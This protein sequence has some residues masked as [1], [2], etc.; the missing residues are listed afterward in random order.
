MISD[1]ETCFNHNL[2]CALDDPLSSCDSVLCTIVTSTTAV[3]PPKKL[4]FLDMEV[5]NFLRVR[6]S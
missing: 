6:D 4:I 2:N 1:I 5:E 3:P